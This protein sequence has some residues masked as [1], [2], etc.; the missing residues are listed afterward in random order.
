MKPKQNK[1]SYIIIL[2]NCE[3]IH[4]ICYPEYLSLMNN[5]HIEGHFILTIRCKFITITRIFKLAKLHFFLIKLAQKHRLMSFLILTSKMPKLSMHFLSV[6][7]DN[8]LKHFPSLVSMQ[9][10][11]WFIESK[12]KLTDLTNRI[13]LSNRDPCSWYQIFSFF[14]QFYTICSANHRWQKPQKL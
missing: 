2:K 5:F 6:L 12:G 3:I 11:H 4:D 13:T 9:W 7:F 10:I 1:V 14:I 8:G